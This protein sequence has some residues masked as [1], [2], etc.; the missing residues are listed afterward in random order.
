M[1]WYPLAMLALEAGEIIACRLSKIGIDQAETRLMM[2]EKVSA[3]LM[4]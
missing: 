1:F 3:G 2:T 4:C